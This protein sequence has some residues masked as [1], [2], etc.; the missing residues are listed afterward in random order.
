MTVVDNKS[1]DGHKATGLSWK[2]SGCRIWQ[3]NK[4]HK[5]ARLNWKVD[6]CNI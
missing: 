2:G 6:D 5:G 1:H 3:I 4:E